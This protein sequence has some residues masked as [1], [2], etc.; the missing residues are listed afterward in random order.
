MN[1]SPSTLLVV[2]VVTAV[3]NVLIVLA[4]VARSR[5]GHARHVVE[6]DGIIS[7]SYVD[8]EPAETRQ[9]PFE[10]WEAAGGWPGSMARLADARSGWPGIAF[11]ASMPKSAEQAQAV[12]AQVEPEV[13]P[14]EYPAPTSLEQ[15][16]L[17]LDDDADAADADTDETEDEGDVVDELEDGADDTAD[18]EAMAEDH[19]EAMVDEEVEVAP[20]LTALPTMAAPSG[21][22][23]RDALTGMLDAASFEEAL[24]HED[25]REQRYRRSATVIVFEL[26]GLA[27]IVDRLG[28]EPGDR[29]EAALGDTITRLARR[30]D[31]V[32]RLERG[33][34]AALLPETDEVAAINYVERI[35]RA[36][37]LWLE[38]GAI[39]MRLA[40]GWAS[41]GGDATLDGALRLATDRMRMESRR[42]SRLAGDATEMPADEEAS[43]L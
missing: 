12:D 36:C 31:Y 40:I 6:L 9:P 14:F 13:E 10:E 30:A 27:K 19:A 34:Y 11:G 20:L 7:S 18:A 32:A 21:P 38:S 25:A 4:L 3:I 29:I 1:I 37:D 24:S 5:A 26:D 22:R 28:S 17:G 42:N 41:T 15:R 8:P 33:R 16:S 23:G 39:A 2:A 43:G 35:R